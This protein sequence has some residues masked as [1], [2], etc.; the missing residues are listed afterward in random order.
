M[1]DYLVPMAAEMP[2]IVVDHVAT[3]QPGTGLGIKG[4]G[5][6]GTVGASAAVWC[7][8]NDALRPLGARVGRQPFTPEVILESLGKVPSAQSRTT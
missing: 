4:V 1:A 7:A 2:D 8:I 3:P 5:E 6:A